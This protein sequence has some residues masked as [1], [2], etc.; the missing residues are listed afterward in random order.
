MLFGTASVP[1]EFWV[2][3]LPLALVISCMDEFRKVLVRPIARIAW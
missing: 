1:V 3:P 2:Y